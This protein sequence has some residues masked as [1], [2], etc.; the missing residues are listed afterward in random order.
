M[1]ESTI[2]PRTWE[3]AHLK[4]QKYDLYSW[5]TDVTRST[6]KTT[7]AISHAYTSLAAANTDF[8]MTKTGYCERIPED[9][10]RVFGD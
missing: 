6:K 1:V 3:S 10:D 5:T 7:K 9:S 2:G 8:R 4:V